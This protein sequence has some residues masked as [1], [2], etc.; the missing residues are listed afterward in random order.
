MRAPVTNANRAV[1]KT[2]DDRR[3]LEI[4]PVK[5]S[6]VFALFRPH[7]GGIAVVV[8]LIVLT[9]VLTVVQPFLVRETVDV[10]IPNQDV[11]LLLWLVGGMIGLAIVTQGIGV[12]QTLLS[13]RIGQT[14]MHSLRT[15]VFENVQRQ[16]LSFFTRSKSG[17]I[18]SRLTN[19]ISAMQSVIT[20][21]TTSIASNLTMAVAT[22]VAM[23][24]LSPTLSL[25]SLIVLPPS[26]YLTRKVAL[27]RRRI[28]AKHQDALA[29]LLQHITENLSLSGALLTKTIGAEGKVADSFN[30]VSRSLI[31]LEIESQLAGRWRMATM[32]IIFA[33]I[34]AFVYLLAGLPATG[35]GMTIGT[36]IAF[37]AMQSQVFR[38][39]MG[40]MNVGAQWVASMALFSRIFEFLDLVP[41]IEEPAHPRNGEVADTSVRF[42]DV[43]FSYDG[44]AQRALDSIS[45]EIAPGTTTAIVGHTGSGKSTI[46]SLVVRLADPSCGRVL[47]GGVDVRDMSSEALTDMIGMV[48]QETYLIHATIRENLLLARPD[49][50]EMELWEALEAARV[51]DLIGELPHGI[52]TVVGSRGH[53]FSGGE[54]QRLTLARTLLRKPKILVLD[55]ATSALDNATERAVNAIIERSSATRLVIAHRMSTVQ[56]ADQILVL[57]RGKIVERGNHESLLSM[58][59]TYAELVRA[60]KRDEG[61]LADLVS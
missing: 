56:Q 55:E 24:A 17:E 23:I 30:A 20:S 52:D 39:M 1:E 60:A 44:G 48:T 3:Q 9:S 6:R 8:G 21:T 10:A 53:R 57:D 28:T 50:S 16:S 34:P 5:F 43:S 33:I 47:V 18:Q 25:L 15:E 61:H 45:F 11:P 41:E 36:L 46:A 29:K 12:V 40:L 42:E 59:G 14:I 2:A 13:T 7:V 32:Q 19:D 35:A 31:E 38:P 37:T 27:T 22:I 58:G 51:A 4:A 54:Q 49:A 26:V